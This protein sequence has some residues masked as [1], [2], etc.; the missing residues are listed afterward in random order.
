M[1]DPPGT[2]ERAR[3]STFFLFL[4][5]FSYANEPF[6]SFVHSRTPAAVL[7]P[8]TRPSLAENASWRCVLLCLEYTLLLGRN[9]GVWGLSAQTRGLATLSPLWNLDA[10]RPPPS[11]QDR[12]GGLVSH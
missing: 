7:Q 5:F 11:L 3:K 4:S 8:L 10:D 6:R 9:L 1:G 2:Y 12:A